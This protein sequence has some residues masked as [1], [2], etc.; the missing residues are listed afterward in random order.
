MS[1]V[2]TCSY[3]GESHPGE[4][5]HESD[6]VLPPE[7]VSPVCPECKYIADHPLS[8]HGFEA[9]ARHLG[10]KPPTGKMCPV[11]P[12]Y[13]DSHYP[14]CNY[15]PET[16][17]PEVSVEAKLDAILAFL[18][19]LRPFMEMAKAFTGGSKSD[20]LKAMMRNGR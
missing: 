1:D 18:E 20:K 14:G 2:D 9:V 6:W 12:G 4:P 19:E 13:T 15:Q 16:P 10:T 8:D 7:Y 5:R 17:V 3:C 11:C